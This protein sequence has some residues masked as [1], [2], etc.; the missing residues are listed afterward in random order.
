[1]AQVRALLDAGWRVP[2]IAA[3]LRCSEWA[4]LK[5]MNDRGWV[6]PPRRGRGPTRSGP[7]APSPAVLH[8]LYFTEQRSIADIA[9]ALG[10]TPARIQGA[11]EAAGIPRRAGAAARF[12]VPT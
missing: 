11:L 7:V 1:V 3:G 6:G 10:S 12:R 5:V 4:V 9:D 2:E 8:R